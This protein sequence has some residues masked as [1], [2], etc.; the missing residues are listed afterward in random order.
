MDGYYYD[1]SW[2]FASL[3]GPTIAAVRELSRDPILISETAAAP[4]TVQPA[5]IADLFHGVRLYDLLGFVWFDVSRSEQ[6][7][8]SSPAAIAALRAGADAEQKLAP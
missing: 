7:G 2:T 4:A 3:F 5:K 6:W 1:P 8:L